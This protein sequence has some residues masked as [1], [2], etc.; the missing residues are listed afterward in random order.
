[1]IYNICFYNKFNSFKPSTSSSST[2]Y[3]DSIW[4]HPLVNE[5]YSLKTL[6][7]YSILKHFQQTKCKNKKLATTNFTNTEYESANSVATT[8]NEQSAIQVTKTLALNREQTMQLTVDPSS[9]T[10]LLPTPSHAARHQLNSL[11]TA[12]ANSSSDSKIEQLIRRKPSA[13]KLKFQQTYQIT[14]DQRKESLS[15]LTNDTNLTLPRNFYGILEDIRYG[16]Y[17]RLFKLECELVENASKELSHES[18]R[19]IS[20][21]SCVDY[22]LQQVVN[23]RSS[24]SYLTSLNEVDMKRLEQISMQKKNTHRVAGVAKPLDATELVNRDDDELKSAANS[25]EYAS[26]CEEDD[27]MTTDD[28]SVSSLR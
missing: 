6:S 19:H 22:L 13:N 26:S 24:L 1:L 12:T 28:E 18:L 27:M 11:L 8:T 3:I 5:I 4:L 14:A 20:S 25:Y 23:R 17:P 21:N 16:L 10:P 15:F 7:V 9:P 2:S